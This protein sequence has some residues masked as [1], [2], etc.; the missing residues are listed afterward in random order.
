VIDRR[1]GRVIG[2]S[3]YHGYD[4]ERSEVEIGWTFLARSHWGGEYNGELKRLMLDHAFRSVSRV[5]FLIHPD[6]VRSQR[7]VEK[8][9]AVRAGSRPDAAGRDSFLYEL[10]APSDPVPTVERHGDVPGLPPEPAGG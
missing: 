7:A 2:Q 10:L 5:V 6:N 8:L 4:P 9:G 3:R 1:D